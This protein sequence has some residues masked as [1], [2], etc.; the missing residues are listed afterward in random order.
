MIAPKDIYHNGNTNMTTAITS[1]PQAGQSALDQ[2]ETVASLDS[3][4]Q[5]L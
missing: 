3:Q 5:R 2:E 4:G 1:N